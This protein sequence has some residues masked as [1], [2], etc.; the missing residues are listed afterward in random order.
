[1]ILPEATPNSDP[2]WFGFPFNVRENDK[3]TRTNLAEFLEEH[4]ILTRQLFAGNLT[5]Q[6]AYKDVEYR[7]SGE[8]TNTDYIM[9]NT[10]FIGVYPGIQQV[11]MDYILSVFDKFFNSIH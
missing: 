6:P 9:R 4:K 8:L 1:M 7:I 3:F 11:H 10:I 5:K 2:S